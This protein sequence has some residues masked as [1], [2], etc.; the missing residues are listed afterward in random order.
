MHYT[1]EK[2]CKAIQGHERGEKKG[3]KEEGHV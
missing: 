3:E 1:S 2:P